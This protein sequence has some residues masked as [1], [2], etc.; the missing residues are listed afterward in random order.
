MSETSKD[1]NEK[2]AAAAQGR[3]AADRVTAPAARSAKAAA[4]RTDDAASAAKGAAERAADATSRVAHT[5]AQGVETGRQ[6]I[7][8]SA[9][10]VAATAQTAWTVIAHR[11]LVAVGVGA[12]LTALTTASYLAGRR[13]QRQTYGPVTRLTGGRI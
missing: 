10:Q 6:A 4:T 12:G 3:R 8:A 13:S 5:A 1:T 2:A 7:V 9:G 11:K